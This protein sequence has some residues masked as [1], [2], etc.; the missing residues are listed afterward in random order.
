MLN[1]DSEHGTEHGTRHA[2]L[3]SKKSLISDIFLKI[4]YVHSVCQRVKMAPSK[5][6]NSHPKILIKFWAG[7]RLST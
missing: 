4:R 7:A 3:F 2:P 5:V 6:E 1:L